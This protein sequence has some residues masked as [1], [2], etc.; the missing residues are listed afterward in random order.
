LSL[1][2]FTRVLWIATVIWSG[3]S[4]H[5]ICDSILGS[6]WDFVKHHV[7]Q[8]CRDL[9]CWLVASVAVCGT[10]AVNQPSAMTRMK[11]KDRK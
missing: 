11:T 6:G 9:S 10:L 1:I 7:K 5:A 4:F 3:V 8:G 2:R